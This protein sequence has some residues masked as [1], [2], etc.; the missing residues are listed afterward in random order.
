MLALTEAP[1]VELAPLEEPA[2]C[3][4]R[5]PVAGCEVISI[6]HI[7]FVLRL[8]NSFFLVFLLPPGV[9][10]GRGSESAGALT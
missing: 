3:E 6:G 10:Y 7:L 5:V 2:H 9:H 4:N 8:T 1:I